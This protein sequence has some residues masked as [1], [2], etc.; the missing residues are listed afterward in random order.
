MEITEKKVRN[1][2]NRHYILRCSQKNLHV[3]GQ[4][5]IISEAMM[6]KNI[7]VLVKHINLQGQESLNPLQKSLKMLDTS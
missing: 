1:I 7:P 5:E 3:M 4:R 6:A 2:G